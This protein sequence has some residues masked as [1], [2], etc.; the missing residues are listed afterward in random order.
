MKC[1]ILAAGY[2]TR[3]YPLTKDTPKPL[4]SV[5][6]KPIIEHIIYRLEELEKI[7]EI[8]V[9][10]N[11]KFYNHFLTWSN[12]FSNGTKITIVNDGT[13]SNEDR[14]G[15]I[16]DIHYVIKDKNILEDTIVIAGDNLFEFSLQHMH[17]F[18]SQKNS[19]VVAFRDLKDKALI[20]GKY[21]T[22]HLDESGKI[23]E[24][25]EKPEIP[26]SSLAST[27]CYLFTK[28][29]FFALERCIAENNQ[30]DNLGDFI[31]YLSA[32]KHVYAYVFEEKWFDIGSHDQLKEA[33]NHFS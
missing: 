27:A 23:L 20:A 6:G 5:A 3:L 21:G 22:A 15:A 31:K 29:D 10:T 4:I 11:D 19:T 16:G 13:E 14:L 32:R 12:N 2:A 9:V 33:E 17:D 8:F 30:P 18:F 26:K 7:D 24:F 28:D 25:Q 1:I